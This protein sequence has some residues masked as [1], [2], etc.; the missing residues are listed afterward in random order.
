MSQNKQHRYTSNNSPTLAAA[1]GAAERRW[2]MELLGAMVAVQPEL[3]AFGLLSS[4]KRIHGCLEEAHVWFI[5][6]KYQREH[7]RLCGS[8]ILR[9]PYAKT[10]RPQRGAPLEGW[11]SFRFSVIATFENGTH[12][13]TPIWLGQEHV[14]MLPSY[15]RGRLNASFKEPVG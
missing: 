12:N 4:F 2:A 1:G 8:Q 5:T 13:N 6:G 11:F 14:Q 9:Q 3:G 10:R 15:M 7:L